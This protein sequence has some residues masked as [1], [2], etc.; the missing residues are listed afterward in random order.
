MSHIP[1]FINEEESITD[2]VQRKFCWHLVTNTLPIP[3]IILIEL[4]KNTQDD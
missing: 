4:N 1:D 3:E 2:A